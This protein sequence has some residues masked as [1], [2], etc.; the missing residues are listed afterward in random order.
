[1]LGVVWVLVIPK[2]VRVRCLFLEGALSAVHGR[3][4]D[5]MGVQEGVG[6]RKG[7]H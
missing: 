2:E 6:Q 1:M 5:A 3:L 4:C 7:V